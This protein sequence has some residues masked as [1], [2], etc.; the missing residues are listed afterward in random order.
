MSFRPGPQRVRGHVVE[1]FVQMSRV[2]QPHAL[3][4]GYV[5][6]AR[7]TGQP[8]DVTGERVNMSGKVLEKHYDKGTSAQKA[9]R[10][11]DY[12]KNI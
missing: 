4:R 12:V 2:R 3:R 9:E 7:N 8:T 5:T 6:A 11:R 10:R 1:R